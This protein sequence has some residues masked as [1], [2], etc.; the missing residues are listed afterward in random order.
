VLTFQRV[1]GVHQEFEKSQAFD[2]IKQSL[3]DLHSSFSNVISAFKRSAPSE[4]SRLSSA[5]QC[6]KSLPLS[7]LGNEFYVESLKRVNV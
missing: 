2:E 5:L 4:L 6:V 7:D 1:N 3:P